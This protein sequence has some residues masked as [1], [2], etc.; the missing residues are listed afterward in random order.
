[1]SPS[2][3]HRLGQKYKVTLPKVQSEIQKKFITIPTVFFYHRM[4]SLSSTWNFFID[5]T[6]TFLK[7]AENYKCEKEKI[8]DLLVEI[9]DLLVVIAWVTKNMTTFIAYLDSSLHSDE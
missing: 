5:L 7:L 2:V 1:M 3:L 8:L 4:T 9:L 6:D